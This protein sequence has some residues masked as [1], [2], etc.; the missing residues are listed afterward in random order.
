MDQKKRVRD[1]EK[2]QNV[3]PL[4]RL[5]ERTK[6]CSLSGTKVPAGM[7]GLLSRR[8]WGNKKGRN[9]RTVKIGVCQ[10][11]ERGKTK[12]TGPGTIKSSPFQTKSREMTFRAG[13]SKR[14]NNRFQSEG[15][16]GGGSER[17]R[18]LKRPHSRGPSATR[19]NRK[20]VIGA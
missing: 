2:V 17:T 12:P 6:N 16:E 13:A 14:G 1:C 8:T 9:K 19:S 4:R 15:G 11:G 7:C 3:N 5:E 20:R 18:S 10:K